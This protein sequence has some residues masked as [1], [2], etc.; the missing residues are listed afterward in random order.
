MILKYKNFIPNRNNL[1]D[2]SQKN[3]SKAYP[4]ENLYTPNQIELPQ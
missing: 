1:R 2:L 3:I 4:T